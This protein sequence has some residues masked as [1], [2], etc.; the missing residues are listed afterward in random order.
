MYLKSL[1]CLFASECLFHSKRTNKIWEKKKQNE[2]SHIWWSEPVNDQKSLQ[3]SH[4]VGYG[5]KI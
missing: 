3:G 2:Y 1:F 5:N 4:L